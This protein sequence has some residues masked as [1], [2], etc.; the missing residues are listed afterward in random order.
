[1]AISLGGY[2]LLVP[3]PELSAWL[4][5]HLPTSDLE[6][7]T[8][9]ISTGA[10]AD[11]VSTTPVRVNL[12]LPNYTVPTPQVMVNRLYWP[13]G[14]SR[15]AHFFGLCDK[16]TLEKLLATSGSLT[17]KLTDESRTT[18]VVIETAMYM[19]PPRQLPATFAPAASDELWL[20]PLV[21]VRYWWQFSNV[22]EL[23][24]QPEDEWA[25]SMEAVA[26]ELSHDVTLTV[27]DIDDAYLYPD[28]LECSRPFENPAVLLDAMAHSVGQRVLRALDGTLTSIGFDRR[29]G[30]GDTNMATS[31]QVYEIVAGGD[32][33]AKAPH[34]ATPVSVEVLFPEYLNHAPSC[35]IHVQTKAPAASRTTSAYTKTFRTTCAALVT[36]AGGTPTNQAELVAL[37]A[38]IVADFEASLKFYDITFAGL[39]TW[40][41]TA[42][43]DAVEWHMASLDR[44]TGEHKAQTRVRSMPY[45]FGVEEMLHQQYDE[46][47]LIAQWGGL[48]SGVTET[49]ISAASDGEVN[50]HDASGATGILVKVRNVMTGEVAGSVKVLF[51]Y[52]F[53][54]CR[55]EIVAEDCT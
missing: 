23:S 3:T 1:M 45:N 27:D 32:F 16:A 51:G 20:L 43:D 10:R 46:D 18:P 7:F 39:K 2:D 55:Y 49:A 36:S 25:Q 44:E 15:W 38:K 53:Q 50:L 47:E 33:S 12:G 13:T 37:T 8:K 30:P 22:A 42:H 26:L 40:E 5:R 24:I 14:A 21:D 54:N 11:S 17:L 9:P 28:P 35:G 31:G 6:I 19:L 34:L 4:E 52:N 48:L 29:P 41:M